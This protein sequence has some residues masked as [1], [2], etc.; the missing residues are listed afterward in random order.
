MT[1]SSGGATGGELQGQV[2]VITGAG[3][4]VGRALALALADAGANIAVHYNS[5][6]DAAE[7][8][9][10]AVRERGVEAVAVQANLGDA[11]AAAERIIEEAAT[12][13][14]P[15]T[16]LVNNA[17]IFEQGGPLDAD[18]AT[19]DAHFNINL[20]APFFLCQ[21]FA[22]RLPADASGNIINLLDWRI[23]RPRGDRLVYTLTKSALATMTRGLAHALAPRIRVNGIAP[24][25]ILPPPGADQAYLD[26]LARQIPL[27]RAGSPEEIWR[28]ALYLLSAAF[29]TGEVIYVTGGEHL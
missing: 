3:V 16:I 13:L 17:S 7:E 29:V 23:D 28:A 8:T 22:R 27:E 10:A 6:A 24:G 5:S 1:S 25:A 18:E 4:R 19:W 20:K 26:R 12:R 11:K 21:A 2:A 15:P 9:V 14:G